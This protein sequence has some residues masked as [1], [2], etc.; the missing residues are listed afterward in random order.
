[1]QPSC[2]LELHGFADASNHAY[3]AVVYLRI[4]TPSRDVHVS[5][6]TS[7]SKVAPIAPLTVPRLELS[8]ALLLTQLVNFV[9]TTLDLSSTPCTCWTDSTIVLTWIRSHPSRWKTFVA[10]R[11][12]KI[13]TDLPAAVWRHVP[14]L[15]N[16]AD[17][18]SRGL[19]GNEFLTHHLWWHGPS[20]LKAPSAEWPE[21]PISTDP[22]FSAEE[23]ISVHVT[24]P[25]PD[26]WDLASRYSSWPKL[27]RVTAYLLKFIRACRARETH[28]PLS[29]TVRAALSAAECSRAKNILDPIRSSSTV[30]R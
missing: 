20:W 29:T 10:N 19:S 18:A 15:S 26:S 5:L 9:K 23:R 17:C 14:T 7:K 3:A 4:S 16:P 12:N 11:V 13:Q 25:A 22:G 27:L 8:A 30:P 21:D 6:L 28:S 1:M 2:R 24:V